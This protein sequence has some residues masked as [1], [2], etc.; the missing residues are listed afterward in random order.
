MIPVGSK[1]I[2]KRAKGPGVI[3][4]ARKALR[5]A[6]D[7]L[8]LEDFRSERDI[9]E[10]EYDFYNYKLH[11]ATT[12]PEIRAA[13][14]ELALA[15]SDLDIHKSVYPD[16][17]DFEAEVKEINDAQASGIYVNRRKVQLINKMIETFRKYPQMMDPRLADD[18]PVKVAWDTW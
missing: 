11:K 10:S 14:R 3:E 17:Q 12:E 15:S 9:L 8:N 1:D 5:R 2:I 7:D 6:T 13:E 16:M 18:H 4:R